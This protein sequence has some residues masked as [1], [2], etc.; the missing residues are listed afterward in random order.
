[1]SYNP[2]VKILDES[3]IRTDEFNKQAQQLSI[4]ND[5]EYLAA[6]ERGDMQKAAEM[7]QE[8]AIAAGYIGNTDY[9]GAGAWGAPTCPHCLSQ[10]NTQCANLAM[11]LD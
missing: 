1:M 2:S 5:A 7:V 10:R 9:Q 3:K 4:E 8:A 6:V 11:G